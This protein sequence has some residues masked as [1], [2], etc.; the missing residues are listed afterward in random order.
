MP[1]L[2]DCISGSWTRQTQGKKEAEIT[3]Q[4]LLFIP[5]MTEKDKGRVE[6]LQLLNVESIGTIMFWPS[7]DAL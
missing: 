2:M 1:R 3:R 6:S 7:H 4:E 5:R